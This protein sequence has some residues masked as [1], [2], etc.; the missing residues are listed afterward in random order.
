M[1][2]S[3]RCLFTKKCNNT[4][5]CSIY[6]EYLGMRVFS[7]CELIAPFGVNKHLAVFA[8]AK[9]LNGASKHCNVFIYYQYYT[10]AL[11]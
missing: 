8:K 1:R 5:G 3:L 11:G 9:A 2:Y 7:H 10:L 6:H 4:I